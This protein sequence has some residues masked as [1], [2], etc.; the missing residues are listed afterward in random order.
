ME[1]LI[2]QRQELYTEKARGLAEAED[3]Y[4][5]AVVG[6]NRE[7]K[8][9]E[10][11]IDSEG[12]S[13]IL[14]TL[15][16]DYAELK[17]R[18]KYT[19]DARE[20]KALSKT[21]LEK[22]K[23]FLELTREMPEDKVSGLA[24][25][26]G[27]QEIYDV[28]QLVYRSANPDTSEYEIVSYIAPEI[29]EQGECIIITPSDG[30]K[31]PTLAKN[32][33]EKLHFFMSQFPKVHNGSKDSLGELTLT[34][35]NKAGGTN[36]KPKGNLGGTNEESIKTN[37]YEFLGTDTTN[38]F[39]YYV[40]RGKRPSE[41][42]IELKTR[43]EGENAQPKGFSEAG[44]VHRFEII[45]HSFGKYFITNNLPS[46]TY[47]EVQEI[48]EDYDPVLD[49]AS[50]DVQMVEDPTKPKFGRLSFHASDAEEVKRLARGRLTNYGDELTSDEFG[51]VLGVQRVS[52]S[53]GV[54]R[55]V[56]RVARREGRKTFFSHKFVGSVINEFGVNGKGWAKPKK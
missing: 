10:E 51:D 3:I 25:L 22:A 55:G 37:A 56:Y 17:I 6:I 41:L 47:K 27:G 20:Y 44:L 36:L 26:M 23:E 42:A 33:E 21:Q 52:I 19:E 28:A 54:S 11:E 46:Q 31:Q 24:K 4:R 43:L 53:A 35:E 15:K 34:F 30:D 14:R 8:D 29:G 7:Y 50:D 2:K 32:L 38:G 1:D 48:R 49:D 9:K 16:T 18:S 45:P 12:A 5:N 39:A 13:A 40:L